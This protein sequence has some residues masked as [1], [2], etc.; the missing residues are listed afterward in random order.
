MD[1]ASS[2]R[3]SIRYE[4]SLLVADIISPLTL[5]VVRVSLEISEGIV[6]R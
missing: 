5:N 4:Y 6:G 2:G 1:A 3:F